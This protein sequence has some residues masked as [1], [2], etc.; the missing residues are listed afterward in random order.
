MKYPAASPEVLQDNSGSCEDR[1]R[2][3][4]GS[5]E[6][7]DVFATTVKLNDGHQNMR[8]GE[9]QVK[10]TRPDCIGLESLVL[11]PMLTREGSR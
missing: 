11:L 5:E 9:R 1:K 4:V 6:M 8:G 7:T 3:G 10:A 2:Q